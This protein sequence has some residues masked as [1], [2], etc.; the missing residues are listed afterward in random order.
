VFVDLLLAIVH[1]LLAFSLAGVLAAEFALVRPGLA[2][3]ELRLV[4]QIDQAF[5]ALALAIVV[6]GVLRV[7]FGLKGWEYYVYNW[8]FWAKMAAFVAVG[9][10]SIRPTVRIVAWRNAARHSTGLYVVPDAEIAGIRRLIRWEAGVFLLI[11][12]F[13]AIMARGVGV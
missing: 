13:A 1:H 10:L 4:A 3:R 12:L 5:G 2:G 6:I 11:P 9:L 7:F 8:A